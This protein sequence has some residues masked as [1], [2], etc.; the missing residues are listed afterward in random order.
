MKKTLD[1]RLMRIETDKR[2]LEDKLSER[3][4]ELDLYRSKYTQLEAMLVQDKFGTQLS[5]GLA[6]DNVLNEIYEKNKIGEDFN[7]ENPFFD[8][9]MPNK[10]IFRNIRGNISK[11]NNSLF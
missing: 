11:K 8:L 7:D 9:V 1:Q 4:E 10:K 6:D 5:I 2:N 3:N